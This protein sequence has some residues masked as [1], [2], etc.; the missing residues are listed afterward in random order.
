MKW[1][2]FNKISTKI[3][4]IKI[5][6]IHENFGYVVITSEAKLDNL[7][8]IVA[9]YNADNSL[10]DCKIETVTA[11]PNVEHHVSVS[12][13]GKYKLMLWSSMD[14]MRPI[15]MYESV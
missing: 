15:W 6:T 14:T 13:M 12:P 9:E 3:F 11:E 2:D 4:T 10:S 1:W 8:L 5:F 7:K